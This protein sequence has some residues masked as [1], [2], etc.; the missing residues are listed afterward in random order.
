MFPVLFPLPCQIKSFKK[1]C[2]CQEANSFPSLPVEILIHVAVQ[3]KLIWPFCQA[4]WQ[5]VSQ[6]LKCLTFNAVTLPL[7]T[8]L[9]EI[10]A[11]CVKDLCELKKKIK[12]SIA[13]RPSLIFVF[14]MRQWPL[15]EQIIFLFHRLK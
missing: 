5:Y 9:K 3:Y 11:E 13:I 15:K 14:F 1:V 4:V 6:S 12:I 8:Q 2:F 10:I 7:G